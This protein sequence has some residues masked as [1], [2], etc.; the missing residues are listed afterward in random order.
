MRREWVSDQVIEEILRGYPQKIADRRAKLADPDWCEKHPESVRNLHDP[1]R[2]RHV[3]QIMKDL[4]N[5][6]SQINMARQVAELEWRMINTAPYYRYVL[7]DPETG[8]V[9]DEEKFENHVDPS[10]PSVRAYVA[11][12]N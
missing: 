11:E 1:D 8:E 10:D 4:A 5:P 6:F 9:L 7:R 12:L 3:V 2:M